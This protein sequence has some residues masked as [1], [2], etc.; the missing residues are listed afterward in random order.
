MQLKEFSLVALLI[1][2]REVLKAI[3]TAI[4]PETIEQVLA[5]TESRETR[6]RKLPA[7]L[8]VCLVIA[9]SIWSSD[10][11]RTVLK[12]LVKGLRIQ[13]LTVGQYWR[14]PSPSSITEARQR[15]GCRAMSQLFK[16]LTRPL[17]TA[18]TPGAFL[19]GL[20]VMAADGTVLD[21]P[22]TP[23][24][25]KVFGYPGGPKG[26]RAAFPKIRLVHEG[27]NS[28]PLYSVMSTPQIST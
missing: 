28:F 18:Q 15:L 7:H 24:N 8:V 4:P 11:M 6:K 22:D 26:T 14:V 9:M 20:R 3:E 25:A 21:V 5:Q 23:A 13:W 27:R 10:S 19:F 17:A 2:S 16:L 12:N 1:E